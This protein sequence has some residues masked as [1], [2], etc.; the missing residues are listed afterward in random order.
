MAVTVIPEDA[1]LHVQDT[2]PVSGS[3]AARVVVQ[4]RAVSVETNAGSGEVVVKE[5]PTAMGLVG[6]VKPVIP[7]LLSP[8]EQLK[9]ASPP[10]LLIWYLTTMSFWFSMPVQE[11]W[12]VLPPSQETV[13]VRL[14]PQGLQVA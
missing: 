5:P 4:A 14:T 11:L 3:A 2:V 6:C 1:L 7:V 12:K 13:L 8:N 10:V 9:R